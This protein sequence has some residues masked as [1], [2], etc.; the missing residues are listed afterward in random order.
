MVNGIYWS[1]GF[2]YNDAAWPVATT[3]NET[4]TSRIERDGNWWWLFKLGSN[5]LCFF[6]WQIFKL[7]W[8]SVAVPSATSRRPRVASRRYYSVNYVNS[9]LLLVELLVLTCGITS[10]LAWNNIAGYT[11]LRS[12]LGIRFFRVYFLPVSTWLIL[13][14]SWKYEIIPI[15]M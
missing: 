1:W 10:C 13:D 6:F 14:E 7:G 15:F 12:D 2:Q 4:T 8:Q 3:L 11:A 9:V 5:W